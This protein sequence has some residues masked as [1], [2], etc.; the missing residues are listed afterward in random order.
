LA[1]TG[2]EPPFAS[3]PKAAAASAEAAAAAAAAAG[4]FDKVISDNEHVCK[5]PG[6]ASIGEVGMLYCPQLI[7]LP[8]LPI[9]QGSG[10]EQES[11]EGCDV[12]MFLEFLSGMQ[13]DDSCASIA[14]RR[15]VLE[16]YIRHISEAKRCCFNLDDFSSHIRQLPELPTCPIGIVQEL[17]SQSNLLGAQLRRHSASLGARSSRKS[18]DAAM[19][20][21]SKQHKHGTGKGK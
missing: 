14:F 6:D 7:S 5:P 17:Y 19:T 15:N 8:N 13:L 4:H 16:T 11:E 2:V 1:T 9:P 21:C 10:F 3:P 12:A 20:R 18:K